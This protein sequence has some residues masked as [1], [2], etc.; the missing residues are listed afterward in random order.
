DSIFLL[1]K[2]VLGL[3]SRPD[4]PC[5]ELA[6]LAD[7]RLRFVNRQAGSGTRLVFDA[8]LA[9]AGLEAAAV[10]GY[11]DEEYTHTAVAALVAAGHADVAFGTEHAATALALHFAPLVDERCY[12]VMSRR[13][14]AALK[15][16]LADF[17]ASRTFAER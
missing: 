15:R 4:L 9:E 10:R 6:A 1:E 13:A 3:L 8:L 16:M 2:R 17:C 12:A 14:D 11:A 5:R 7:G